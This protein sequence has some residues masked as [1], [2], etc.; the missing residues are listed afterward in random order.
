MYQVGDIAQFS[1]F[2]TVVGS[3]TPIYVWKF[4]DGNVQVSATNFGSVT[5]RLNIGGNPSE[6]GSAP[7]VIPYRC[8]ICDNL[9]NTVQVV[10]FTIPVNNPPSI[11]GAPTINP[12][13]QAFPF[14]TVA[15]VQAYDMENHGV[16]FYWYYGTNPIGGKDTTSTVGT[17]SG[18][19]MGTITGVTPTLFRNQLTTTVNGSGTIL[20]CKLVDGDGGT[21]LLNL[22]LEGFDP[23]APQFSVAAVPNDITADAST[24]SSAVIAPGQV[25][26][27]TAYASDPSPGQIIFTWYLYGT[28]GWNAPDIPVVSHGTTTALALGFRN[29]FYR[30]ISGE[31]GTGERDAIVSA[32]NA[33]TGKT[34]FSTIPVELIQNSAPVVAS[35]GVYNGITDQAITTITKLAPPARTTI[36]LAGTASDAN[37]DVVYFKWDVTAP[38]TP[39][40]YTLYGHDAY[41]DIS[42]W[43]S[44]V[45]LTYGQVTAIDKFGA[46][47]SSF[48]LP[49]FTIL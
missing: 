8:D 5:K 46:L 29:D 41:I 11:Y 27:F 13:N 12:N 31:V 10:P 18:T 45:Y 20:T 26:Q 21:N 16:S 15:T 37:N 39:T 48:T 23:N 30:N 44:G 4:W 36:R 42:D 2:G 43:N 17:V 19:Y 38:V 49:Q 32:T 22:P 33:S 14:S 24:L 6:G 34:V 47:S 3:A 9:G 28:N 35:V 25:V 7:Y 1:T 40:S